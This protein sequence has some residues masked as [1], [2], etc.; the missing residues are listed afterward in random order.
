MRLILLFAAIAVLMAVD[1]AGDLGS[2]TDPLHL[3]LEASVF[4][5]ASA[6][7]ALL[8][9]AVAEARAE[10]A[11][12]GR[13][14]V[15]A[16]ADAERWRDDARDVL[17]GLGAAMGRQFGRWALTDAER[18]VALLLLQGLSHKE[19]ATTRDTGARTVRQQALAVYRKAGVH[20][21]AELAAFFLR[22]VPLSSAT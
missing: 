21:R 16:Q 3:A 4:A 2:R 19:I 13:D 12:L 7:A 20:S 6:G 11:Q 8:W 14:L 18:G 22:D 17:A 10:A 1:L 15:A 9:R 5:L